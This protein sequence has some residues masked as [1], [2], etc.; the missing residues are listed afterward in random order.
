MDRYSRQ[1]GMPQ[2]GSE[3]QERLAKASAL[4]VGAGGLGSA[5]LFCLAGAGVGRIGIADYDTIAESNLNRQFLHT[6]DGIGS[7]KLDSA[8]VRLHAFNPS[9][10]YEPH[11][12]K[13]DEGNAAA[14]ITDYD[15]IL[16]AVDNLPAR[17]ALNRACFKMCK[18]LVSGGVNGM[19]GSLQIVEP[20]KTPCLNCLYGDSPKAVAA[21]SFAPVVSTIS[22]LMAQAALLLML[23][24]PNPLAGTLLYFNGESMTFEKISISRN[25]SCTVCGEHENTVKPGF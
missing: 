24:L 12:C 7:D 2:I 9:L 10:H 5:L 6:T 8:L 15:I 25:P 17:A 21:N 4:V 14:L 22:S 18:P 11:R 3:G 1:I 20:G 16:A 23:G 13:V 19:F